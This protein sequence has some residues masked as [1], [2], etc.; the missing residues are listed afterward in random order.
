MNDYLKRSLLREVNLGSFENRM[1]AYST[2]ALHQAA[3]EFTL[4][5]EEW[6]NAQAAVVAVAPLTP[7]GLI[8][9]RVFK[10]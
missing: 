5:V 4:T 2:L 9:P 8:D 3:G 7:D 6:L 10:S 1:R